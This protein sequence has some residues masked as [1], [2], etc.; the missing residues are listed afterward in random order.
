MRW[1]VTLMM[2]ALLLASPVSAGA[3]HRP[4]R[5]CSVTGDICQSTTRV[6]GVR[7]LTIALAAEYFHWYT[8]CVRAPDDSVTCHRFAIHAQGPTFGSSIRWA[9]HFPRKGPGPYTVVWKSGG[10]RVGH[11]L[12]FHQ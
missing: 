6:N 3:S 12:G 1:I 7:R 8:L 9:R 2:T 4:T 10:H 11:I 5:Y